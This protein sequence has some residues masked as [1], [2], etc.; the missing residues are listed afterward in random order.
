MEKK[1]LNSYEKKLEKT[2]RKNSVNSY[3]RDIE[4]VYEYY[5]EKIS[6]EKIS[7]EKMLKTFNYFFIEEYFEEKKFSP[8]SYNRK[9][10]SLGKFFD[11]LVDIGIVEKNFIKGFSQIPN[12]QVQES[13]KEKT[14]F[15]IEELKK[16]LDKASMIDRALFSIMFVGGAR[17]NEVLSIKLD[18]IS[19]VKNGIKISID[20]SIVKNH[21]PKK[22][23]IPKN[24]FVY[25]Y[26][27]KYYEARLQKNTNDEYLFIG[28]DGKNYVADGENKSNRVSQ[29]NK[30]LKTAVKKVGL[31][32]ISTHCFRHSFA[33][34]ADSKAIPRAN[35]FELLTW[36]DNSV[37]KTTYSNHDSE[38]KDNLNFEI[39]RKILE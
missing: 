17:C 8:S 9:I 15:S 21:M 38:E 10:I 20:K 39:V 34:I 3:I 23:Y 13:I 5:E 2:L 11:W 33:T 26:F 14:I 35:I 6:E 7:E 25:D 37:F 18:D 4:S 28:R 30:R 16:I 24:T 12:E 19:E 32:D 36:K 29:V 22:F 31:K 27:K 1:I